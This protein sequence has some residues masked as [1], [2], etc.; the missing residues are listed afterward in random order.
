MR[1]VIQRVS[2]ASVRVDGGVVGRI[3]WGLCGRLPTWREHILGKP[4]LR[5][6]V[7]ILLGGRHDRPYGQHLSLD[8]LD[9]E[10]QAPPLG[11]DFQDLHPHRVPRLDDLPR[12][13]HVVLGQL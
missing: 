3:G 2:E 1:A 5:H 13:L 7:E 11:I 8:P 12:V 6:V 10:R 9:R 4:Q